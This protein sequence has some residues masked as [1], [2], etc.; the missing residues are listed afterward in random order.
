MPPTSDDGV[1]WLDRIAGAIRS[2]DASCAI[3]LGL[4]MED[5]E[6]DRRIGPTEAARVCDFLCMH[7]YP[8]YAP[9][10]RG[11]TDPEL[12]AFLADI[13]RWLAGTEKDVLFA[14]FGAPT[15][16]GDPEAERATALLSEDEAARYTERAY[17][18]LQS[19]G[20]IGGLVWCYAD[21]D[22]AIWSEPPLDRAPHERHFGLWRADGSAKPA[23]AALAEWSGRPRA[24]LGPP[25]WSASDRREFEQ[26]P[27][28]TL[29]R[30]YRAYTAASPLARPVL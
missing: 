26:A 27:R 24:A 6:D 3:T 1:R 15:R 8:I 22:R 16:N 28:E 12:V 25:R 20:A 5:L 17:R 29:I 7:G 18:R 19:A 4:H 10:C 9:W 2:S 14:E 11:P 21:Y 23:A 13:T 30:L